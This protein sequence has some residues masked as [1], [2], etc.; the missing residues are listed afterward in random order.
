MRDAAVTA[1]EARRQLA[2]FRNIAVDVRVEQQQRVAA[3]GNLPHAR[4]RMAPVRVSIEMPTG[5]PLIS[6]SSIGARGD[7]RRDIPQLPARSRD[8]DG[9]IPG[10][11]NA[12]ERHRK[13]QTLLMWSPARNAE[14]APR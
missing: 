14:A 12:N 4:P 5:T 7:R 2:I 8:A 10:L 9:S 13:D 1:V 11:T 3:D 6:A